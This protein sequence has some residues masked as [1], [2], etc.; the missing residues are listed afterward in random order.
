MAAWFGMSRTT[1]AGYLGGDAPA[2]L[3]VRPDGVIA[4][5]LG[6]QHRSGVWQ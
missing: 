5:A 3:G 2:K 1:L 4:E 6:C